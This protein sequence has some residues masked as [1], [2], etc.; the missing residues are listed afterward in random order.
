M[1]TTRP[2]GSMD[3][4]ELRRLWLLAVETKDLDDVLNVIAGLIGRLP[5]DPSMQSTPV[6]ICPCTHPFP[7]DP[8]S[9]LCPKC[10][11]PRAR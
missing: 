11:F 6:V 9:S 4:A 1:M 10:G 2:V 8:N 3:K 5:D 7:P